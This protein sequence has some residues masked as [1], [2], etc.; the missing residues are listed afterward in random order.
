M[1][2][3]PIIP[4]R[5]EASGRAQRPTAEQ[6]REIDRKVRLKERRQVMG[7]PH[8]NGADDPRCENPFGRFCIRFKLAEELYDAGEEYARL[9]RKWRLARGLPSMDGVFGEGS[10]EEPLYADPDEAWQAIMR[11][12]NAM[13]K[14]PTG[15]LAVTQMCAER[16]EVPDAMQRRAIDAIIALAVHFGLRPVDRRNVA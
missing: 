7:Q 11:A 9:W 14:F 3:P 8:R 16:Q 15:R 6:L 12:D 5:R 13:G 10:G 2:A 1:N 4:K